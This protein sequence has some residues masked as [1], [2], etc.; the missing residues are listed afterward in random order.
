MLIVTTGPLRLPAY[1]IP[2][3]GSGGLV[4]CGGT[5]LRNNYSTLPDL[6][7]AKRILQDYYK[8]DRRLAG[9]DGR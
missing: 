6:N 3:P 5:Y 1:I 4:V 7:E 2:R 8:L 9:P